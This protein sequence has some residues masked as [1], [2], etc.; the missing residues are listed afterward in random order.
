MPTFR[1]GELVL[2]D[3]ALF[4]EEPFELRHG[5]VAFG[6]QAFLDDL[7]DVGAGEGKPGF[8]AALDLGEVVGLA[9]TE[10]RRGRRRCL[11]GT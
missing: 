3:V 7:V 9:A 8:E 10:T 4:V 2:E 6:E 11:P 1:E 5:L